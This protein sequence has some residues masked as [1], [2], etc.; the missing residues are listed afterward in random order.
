MA[1]LPAV[2]RAAAGPL[3]KLMYAYAKRQFGEVPEPF[4]VLAH[5]RKLFTAA[6][7][8]EGMANRAANVLPAA[9]RD[10]AVY[11]VAWVVGCSWCVDF[12]SMLHR[13]KGLDEAQL[14]EIADYAT[15]PV[16]NDD[17]RAAIAYA[18]AMTSDPTEITDEQVADL[19]RRFGRA[20]LVELTYEIGLENMRSR[21][22]SALGIT[23]QGFNS[24]DACRVPWAGQST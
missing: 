14:R 2:S 15:S 6:A 20:G 5:H 19:E 4:A 8:H 24:G 23:A 1:R 16:Y 17:Q 11:R 12:G 13:L 9:V 22:Y 21:T 3:M 7:V 10:L 18:D